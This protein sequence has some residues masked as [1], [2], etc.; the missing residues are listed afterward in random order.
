MSK[1]KLQLQ[2]EMKIAQ[3]LRR[4]PGLKKAFLDLKLNCARC[5]G[6]ATESISFVAMTHGMKP[7][8]FIQVLEK[9]LKKSK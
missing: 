1:T 3:A 2:P 7:E 8:Q 6:A 4:H 9:C 5:K